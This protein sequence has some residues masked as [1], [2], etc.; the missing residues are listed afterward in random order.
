[1]WTDRLDQW[2]AK[3]GRHELPWRLT[4][5]PWE[6]LVSEVMLQQTSVT[7]VLPRWKRFLVRWPDPAACAGEP[8]QEVLR[9]WH[10]LGYPRR[11]RSLWL[12][13][14]RVASEGW[15]ADESGL[16]ALPGVGV[17]TA[18]ALLA[19]S[20]VGLDPEL[21][22]RDVNLGRIG[23]RAGLGR[24]PQDVA[25][26]VLDLVLADARPVSMP[27]REFSYALFDVGAAHCQAVPR[28]DGCPLAPACAFRLSGRPLAVPR[29]RQPPYRGSLRQLRGA[30]LAA[31]LDGD[32][33]DPA[34]VRQE[35]S[36]LLGPTAARFDEALRGLM[37]DGLIPLAAL[38]SPHANEIRGA[39]RHPRSALATS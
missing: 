15:P 3:H 29:R 38:G 6:V 17:Y 36:D 21:P 10:G 35:V 18:R 11:A 28:C 39:G 7:R 33:G 27:M 1:M 2:Y 34:S 26:R 5:D 37:A 4:A 19:F 8:L 16:R 32:N 14:A 13:A 20:Q 9:E 22:P 24:E 12:T 25:L 31:V 23:A 30:I